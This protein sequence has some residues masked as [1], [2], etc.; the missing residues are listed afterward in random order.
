MAPKRLCILHICYNIFNYTHTDRRMQINDTPN[1]PNWFLSQQH[2]FENNLT[3]FKGMPNLKFL[4]IG[5]Y[6][7]DASVWILDN[8]L[9]DPSSTLTDID[10]WEGSDEQEHKAISFSDVQVYYTQRT[11][12]YN[13]LLSIRSKSEYALPN[14]KETYDFIYIDGD[15]T[16]KGV[17]DDAESAWGIL[18]PNGILAFDD[19]MWGQD[20][21][22]H[23]TPK[24]AIDSFLDKYTGSYE[25]LTKEYQ[26]WLVKK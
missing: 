15:H 14:L 25:L 6:T 26:V 18:K 12:K 19:Y 11:E 13:N 3:K 23:L 20:L 17:R 9:T 4:Q 2:N 16:A 10:T 7:G 22:L 5:A 21:P 24:P 8:I 1:L